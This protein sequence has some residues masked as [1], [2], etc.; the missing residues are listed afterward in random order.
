MAY[1]SLMEPQ[2][3]G[4]YGYINLLFLCSQLI[5]GVLV[6]PNRVVDLCG[7]KYCDVINS[8]VIRLH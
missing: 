3:T 5:C 1:N 2:T 7:A 6:D 8:G 4:S